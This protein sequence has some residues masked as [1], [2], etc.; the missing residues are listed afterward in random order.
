MKMFSPRFD[1]AISLVTRAFSISPF[2]LG[3]CD[4]FVVFLV[5][6]VGL[7]SLLL[8]INTSVV[9]FFLALLVLSLHAINRSLLPSGGLMADVPCLDHSLDGCKGYPDDVQTTKHARRMHAWLRCAR[10][11]LGAHVSP[12]GASSARF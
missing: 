12:F 1:S 8:L 4:V 11:S 6:Y 2:F 5:Q 7:L 9:F 3:Y 10:T